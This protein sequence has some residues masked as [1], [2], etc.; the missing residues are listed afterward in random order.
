MWQLEQ[1]LDLLRPD[2]WMTYHWE[3][4]VDAPGFVPTLWSAAHAQELCATSVADRLR[5]HPGEAWLYLNEAHLTQQAN[6]TPKEAVDLA[7]W[8]LNQAHGLGVPVS[9]C[10]PN[11]AINMSAQHVG[12]MSGQEWWRDWLR[13]LR[14]SGIVRPSYHGVHF[15]DSSSKALVIETWRLLRDEWRWQWIGD[16][17]PVITEVC[18]HEY[19]YAR[20][21]EVMEAVWELYRIGRAEGPAGKNGA[22]GA[23]W[24]CGFD[25]SQ[26]NP[27]APCHWTTC[28]LTEVDPGKVRT[29]RLTPLGRRWLEL[30]ARNST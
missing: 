7:F 13:K 17:P 16:G 21:V 23:Y 27:Y 26:I 19:P 3:Q 2:R 25:W 24:F 15:Y 29:M 28:A 30:K 14:Q 12:G 4:P 20:Q 18:A 5:A 8:F 6:M 11:C 1:A 22:M 9:W 10:G